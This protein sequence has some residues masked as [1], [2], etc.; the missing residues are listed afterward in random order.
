VNW[1]IRLIRWL[2][3]SLREQDKFRLRLGHSLVLQN[4]EQELYMEVV[5]GLDEHTVMDITF[6]PRQ[7]LRVM[8]G[9]GEAH[10]RLEREYEA[11][12]DEED[13]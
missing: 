13:R 12:L 1:R 6:T 3:R 10:R 2:T 8:G 5:W 7:W 9:M 4:P 11:L